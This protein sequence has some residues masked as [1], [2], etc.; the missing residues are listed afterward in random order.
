MALQRAHRRR[1]IELLSAEF[2]EENKQENEII[3]HGMSMVDPNG[4]G[5]DAVTSW[6]NTITARNMD[7]EP[8]MRSMT[9]LIGKSSRTRPNRTYTTKRQGAPIRRIANI[10]RNHA[11]KPDQF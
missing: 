9:R 5:R 8:D 4:D 2:P 7:M 10:D 11:S 1:C 3:Q 6:W